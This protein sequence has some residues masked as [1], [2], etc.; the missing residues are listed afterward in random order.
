MTSSSPTDARFRWRL[1]LFAT[2]AALAALA[3]VQSPGLVVNDTKYDLSVRPGLFLEK[4]LHLWDPIGEFGQVQ[5]QA[6]GY[7][8]PMG[9]FFALGHLLQAPA[10]VVQRAWW[11]VILIV[12]FLGIVKLCS[13]LNIGSPWARILAGVVFALSPRML[14]NLGPISIEN[15]PSAIAPWVLIPLVIGA[16][17]GSAR[18]AA[19][20]SAFAAAFVGAVNAVASAAILPISALWLLTRGRGSR[21][22]TMMRWWPLLVGL[23][24]LWW[25]VPLLVL[26]RYSPPFLDYIESS[27][28]TTV[29][30]TLADALRGTTKWVPYVN[31]DYSAGRTLLTHPMVI[32]QTGLLVIFGLLGLIRRD[33]AERRFL[34]I[35]LL[36]GVVLVTMG[37]RGAFEGFFSGDL[38]RQLDQVL[39]PLRNTHKWDVLIRLPLVLGLAHFVSVVGTRLEGGRRQPREGQGVIRV[40]VATL[41]VAAFLGS[42]SVAF[43]VSLASVGSVD[44]SPTYWKQASTWLETH[45]DGRRTYVAPGSAFGDYTWGRP[46]DEAIQA[47][48]DAP[49]ATRSAIP[50]VPGA[51]IR[52]MD[53]IETEL[54]NGDGSAGLHDYLSRAGI[55]Y[56]LVRNDLRPTAST[57]NPNVVHAAVDSTPG[58]VKVASFGP[59][60]GGKARLDKG[61]RSAAFVNDGVQAFHPA[62]EIYEVLANTGEAS[63]STYP[64]ADL[65]V[66][67]GDSASLLRAVQLGAVR[68][69]PVE[70]ARDT[71]AKSKPSTV[72]LTDGSRRQEVDF[73]RVQANRSA[74]VAR[75]EPWRTSR[76]VHDYD[77]GTPTRLMTLARLQ[78]AAAVRAT[79][80]ASDASYFGRI[81][82]AS[83]PFSAVDNDSATA[84][85]S[86][87]PVKGRHELRLKLN[88]PTEVDRITLSSPYV[89]G[90]K[91]RTISVS[92]SAGRVSTEIS[93]GE[94]KT[95]RTSAGRTTFV[96]ITAR[97]DLGQALRISELKV[98][99][100]RVSRPLVLPTLPSAWGV[101]D[102]I[103][104]SVASGDR[105]GCVLVDGDQRCAEGNEYLG[106]DG[107][108]LDR[109]VTIPT[110]A[111]FGASLQVAPWGRDKLT[112]AL[113]FGRG[114]TVSASSQA[115]D[116]ALS[117]A[118]AAVDD[119]LRTGWVAS[120]SD[121]DPS[122]TAQW[123]SDQRI[124]GITVKTGRGLVAAK[125][126][127]V[128]IDFGNGSTR[129]AK[130]RNGKA[131]F[132]PVTASRAVVHFVNHDDATTVSI[133]GQ[134]GRSLAVGVSELTFS[135]ANLDRAPLSAAVA[136]FGCGSGPDI[137]VDGV[138]TKTQLR[139]SPQQLYHGATVPALICGADGLSLGAG[140]NEITIR[141]TATVRPIGIRLDGA[142]VGTPAIG[143][144][145]A[146]THTD[147]GNTT[148]HVTKGARLLVLRINPSDGW[149]AHL[150]SK[151][152]TPVTVDGWQQ[153]WRLPEGS[154]GAV[155][156]HFA[157]DTIYRGGLVAGLIGILLVVLAA[158]HPRFSRGRRHVPAL[159]PMRIGWLPATVAMGVTAGLLGGWAGLAVAA[160]GWAVGS[161]ICVVGF[162]RA[163]SWDAGAIVA[164]GLATVYTA[165]ALRPWGGELEWMGRAA[166]P[167]LLTLGVL[168]A[169]VAGAFIPETSRLLRRIAGRS[170][171]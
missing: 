42:A 104:L 1:R 92:T 133:D 163:A 141:G 34:I 111:R 139:A 115:T 101:P 85:V 78:G 49:W 14:T 132:A 123:A 61:G 134:T 99:G 30:A 156:L 151:S 25:L 91:T 110:G 84:W 121:R 70:F 72:V 19:A 43:S 118:F 159:R 80:S 112:S 155:R 64:D 62:I 63:S 140:Q 44:K 56:L 114:T 143:T 130:L 98:P 97:S 59:N 75:D 165:Y 164:L 145:A 149:Q 150:G 76:V 83:Q 20:R 122:L 15:W 137:S 96:A 88:N 107:R 146:T 119:D 138:P 53:A 168:S 37:H 23:A 108:T 86:G 31:S 57:P 26:G 171:R 4:V 47:L 102:T 17:R 74:S 3:F 148:V 120:S 142:P 128:V 160:A 12:A 66:F 18:Q 105:S 11:A 90:A 65:P 22:G 33:L 73:G 100:V 94:T 127:G 69:Q 6:Y 5:N 144:P 50:L 41:A 135:G 24:T 68:N 95:I 13:L 40:G 8:F 131:T 48:S 136:D 153:G 71:S 166:W 79:S 113:Q 158:T 109:V 32:L 170:T 7:L 39:A 129:K 67:V 116:Q 58:L 161:G 28:G 124:S 169:A 45:D 38:N 16:Q 152:L 9:P 55:G 27:T 126:T 77:T 2:S 21:R 147:A 10:W 52:M 35:S 29:P 125:A 46:M 82:P 89:Y 162:R 103:A 36:A 117:G 167:Q 106:E 54:V 154:A 93:P 157:P 60:V 87:L 51:T 81:D